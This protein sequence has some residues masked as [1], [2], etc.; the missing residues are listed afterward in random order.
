MSENATPSG[1]AVQTTGDDAKQPQA[2]AVPKENSEPET[3]PL[4]AGTEPRPARQ[5]TRGGTRT[6]EVFRKSE[7]NNAPE[8]SRHDDR[9]RLLR[10]A[11]KTRKKPDPG[12][13]Y[14][15]FEIGLKDFVWS[16]VDRGDVI[17]DELCER[18]SV[19]LKRLDQIE[20]R[21]TTKLDNLETRIAVLEMLGE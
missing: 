2:I 6:R 21:L 5:K 15:A 1:A 9:I 14:A 10:H 8:N 20:Q 11:T 4:S 18:L 12:E 7:L 16:F 17:E 13:S 3:R 19:A